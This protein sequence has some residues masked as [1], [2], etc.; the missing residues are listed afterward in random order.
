MS[1]IVFSILSEAWASQLLFC[2]S[3]VAYEDSFKPLKAVGD[4][5]S[6]LA[7]LWESTGDMLGIGVG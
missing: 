4:P 3:T 6:V 7:G 2:A 5:P 1:S